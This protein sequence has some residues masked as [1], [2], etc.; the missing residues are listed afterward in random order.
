MASKSY[1]RDS[2]NHLV[3]NC[4]T[5]FRLG[6]WALKL[7]KLKFSDIYY[8]IMSKLPHPNCYPFFW[9]GIFTAFEMLINIGHTIYGICRLFIIYDSSGLHWTCIPTQCNVMIPMVWPTLV[10]CCIAKCSLLQ[11]NVYSK[12]WSIMCSIDHTNCGPYSYIMWAALHGKPH[13]SS[14]HVNVN[15]V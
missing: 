15:H 8:H 9:S 1:M 13:N 14:T 4:A 11:N 5:P 6:L 7:C 12:F 10:D 3:M 2:L